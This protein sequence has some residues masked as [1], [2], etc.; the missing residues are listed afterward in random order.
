MNYNDKLIVCSISGG[1]DSTAMALNLLEQGYT[2]NDFTRIFFDTGW[3][4]EQTYTYLDYLETII[5]PIQRFKLHVEKN[6]EYANSI[7]QIENML[8]FESPFVRLI[9]KK[10]IFPNG[11]IKYCTDSLKLKLAKQ[12][13]DSLNCDYVNLVGVRAEESI[14]RSKYTEWEYNNRFDCYTHR[15]LLHWTEKNV[16]DIH[17]RFNITPNPLYLRGWNRVGCYPCIYSNKKEISKLEAGRV[18]VIKIIE[19]DLNATFFKRNGVNFDIEQTLLWS[20]TSHGGKQFMLF[21]VQ[22]PTCEKWG[23]CSFAG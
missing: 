20:K 1:K 7:D 17:H 10:R 6:P 16:I 5:G 21:D 4:H 9:Y 23:L 13:Y 15:P 3:E 19:N 22:T 18:E 11:R 12:Y 8:G 2:P 14:K